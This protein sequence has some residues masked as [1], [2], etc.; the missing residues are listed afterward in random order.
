M[1]EFD[2]HHLKKTR[3]YDLGEE[4]IASL[5]ERKKLL[6]HACCGPCSC[7]PLV[8][9]CPHF[10]VTIYY[11]NPNIYPEAEYSKRLDELKKLLAYLKRDHGFSI[12]L[13]VPPYD[14]EAY[15]EHMKGYEDMPEGSQRCFHCY[16]YRMA[17]AYQYAEDN[18]FDYF[19][20]VMTVSR[21]KSSVALNQIGEK[22]SALHPSVPYLY[23]DFKK[24]GGIDKGKAIREAYDLYN[25]PYCGCRNSYDE[26]LQRL[27]TQNK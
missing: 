25:Q 1:N 21:Q 5:K 13:V 19:T 17:E 20:T 6:L 10:D 18:N 24:K 27:E 12:D 14:P 26:Y 22:L 16:E 3:Y 8:Y 23:S 2:P 15:Y 7:F 11:V 9:L 4:V